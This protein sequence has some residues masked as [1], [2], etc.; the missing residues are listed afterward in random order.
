[1]LE[2]IAK[3]WLSIVK[4]ER[5]YSTYQKYLGICQKYLFRNPEAEGKMLSDL[6]GLFGSLSE[7]HTFSSSLAQSICCVFNQ[8]AAYAEE[9]YQVKPPVRI[10]MNSKDRK[11]QRKP[12]EKTLTPAEQKRFLAFLCAGLE[13][14]V[15]RNAVGLLLCLST[16]MRLG[17]LCAL[18]WED[19]D[20]EEGLIYVNRTVQRLATDSKTAAQKRTRLVEGDPK[21][22]FSKRVIP[23]S[24]EMNE[25]LKNLPHA[26]EYVISG[27]RP[28]DPRTY[29]K[30]YK[31]Y[32]EKAGV[33]DHTF[34]C[35]RHTFA[36]NCVDNGIDTKSLS[37]ILGHSDVSI[38]LNRYVH[39]STEAKRKYMNSLSGL[40]TRY[41]QDQNH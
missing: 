9:E 13:D 4:K 34:H 27:N 32:L 5:K 7:S 29:E 40:Y 26:G 35:L 6:P 16:G 12:A 39:P 38:T 25:T 19:I 15:D 17:E 1:M 31:R 21:S 14:P 2:T 24:L 23:L 37:E 30:R 8:I 22:F 33:N 41:M 11:R 20:F 18:K 28:T 10:R 36:T 3:E